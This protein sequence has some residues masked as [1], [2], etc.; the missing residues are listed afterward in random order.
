MNTI[1]WVNDVVGKPW[2]DR[3]S[4]PDTYDCWGL[5]I[6]SFRRLDEDPIDEVSGYEEGLPIEVAGETEQLTG[7]WQEVIYPESG[8]VFCVYNELGSMVHVGRIFM[9]EKAGYYC[10]HSRGEG[11]Q[12]KADKLR[13][14]QRAYDNVKFFKRVK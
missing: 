10:I 6:D 2:K 11:G 9:I 8:L 4:G 13:T 14:I 1:E 5:V 3:T 12:V 7:N